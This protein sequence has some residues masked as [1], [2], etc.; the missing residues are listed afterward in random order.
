MFKHVLEWKSFDFHLKKL[1]LAGQ[2]VI[3]SFYNPE[4]KCWGGLAAVSIFNKK[5]PPS[6]WNFRESLWNSRESLW[7]LRTTLKVVLDSR[8]FLWNSR[9]LVGV[10]CWKIAYFMIYLKDLNK[11]NIL[12]I[13]FHNFLLNLF[14]FT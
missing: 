2:N 4:T 12:F 13:Q 14:Y 3:F 10:F 11:F 9:N 5:R 6:F 1:I 8:D 7:N